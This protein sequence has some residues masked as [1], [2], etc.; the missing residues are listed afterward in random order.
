[1]FGH[2]RQILFCSLER[3]YYLTC[4]DKIN[5]YIDYSCVVVVSVRWYSMSFLAIWSQTLEESC[6]QKQEFWLLLKLCVWRIACHVSTNGPLVKMNVYKI[7]S[8]S[9]YLA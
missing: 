6:V 3:N 1:M 8:V 4:R 7:L 9:L 5:I 2:V